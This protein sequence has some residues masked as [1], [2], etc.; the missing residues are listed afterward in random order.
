MTTYT[1]PLKDMQ[2][3]LRELAGLEDVLNLPGHEEHNAELVDAVLDAAAEVAS[4]EWAPLN[5]TGDVEGVRLAEDGSVRMPPGF[6]EAYRAFVEA[7]WNGLRFEPE[8]GGQGL[9]RLVDAAVME[10]WSASNLAFSLA[11]MLTQGAIEALQLRGSDQQKRIWL[12]KLVSGEW[13]G[14]MNLTEPQ[15][16]SDLALIRTRATPTGDHYLIKGQKIFITFGEH[17]LTENIVHLVLGRTPDAPEGVKG[18][19]LFLVPKFLVNA[20]GGLGARNDVRC[21]S[22]EHKLGIHASPTATLSFGDNEGAIG[23]LIGEENRGLEVM[24]VMMNAARFE[25]GLQG[26]AIGERAYQ[27]ALGCAKERVQGKDATDPRGPSVPIIQHPDVRRMLMSMKSRVEAM[28]AFAY[29]VAGCMDFAQRSPDAGHRAEAQAQVDLLIPVLKGWCTETGIEV[30]STGLQVHGGMGYIEETGAAQHLRDARITTIYEGTTGIQA[31]DLVNR[32]LLRDRGLAM[33]ALTTQ[34]TAT[35]ARLDAEGEV[36]LEVIGQRLRGA[37]N[38]LS[39]AGDW[40]IENASRAPAALAG[41]V[42]LLHLVGIVLGGWQMAR[43]ALAAHRQLAKRSGDTAFLQG[44]IATALFFADQELTRASGLH[45][46]TVHAGPSTMALAVE[47][48]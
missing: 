15:A 46:A 25:V 21:I 40:M 6:V 31:L 39:E 2:F 30:A 35:C 26:L 20:D 47:Q 19:S 42:P 8:H 45:Q 14:T 9:P 43:A 16:G 1:A 36:Y 7:G 24:F 29:V 23:Y 12:P 48:F 32:K 38:A 28:R 17:D 41:A 22:L 3:C 27:L 44:K 37:V 4:T 34:V 11:P 33:R 10:M 13:A 5:R 18:I